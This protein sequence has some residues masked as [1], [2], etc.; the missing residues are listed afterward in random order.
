MNFLLKKFSVKKSPRVI[1]ILKDSC[2]LSSIFTIA[3]HFDRLN[4]SGFMVSGFPST[5]GQNRKIFPCVYC[6]IL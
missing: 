5:N 2:E 4:K 1:R 6:Y 3:T